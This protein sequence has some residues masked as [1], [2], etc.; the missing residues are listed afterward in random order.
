FATHT[1]TAPAAICRSAIS[2]HLCVFECGRNFLPTLFTYWAIF[3]ML[4]SKRSRS[5][6]SAGVGISLRVMAGRGYHRPRSAHPAARA[7]LLLPTDTYARCHDHTRETRHDGIRT[8][9]PGRPG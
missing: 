2:G 7:A 8:T 1:P 6:R 9:M 4:R 3:W 5:S